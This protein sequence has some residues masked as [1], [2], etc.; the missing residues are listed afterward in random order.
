MRQRW[1]VASLMLSATVAA[2]AGGWQPVWATAWERSGPAFVH[3]VDLRVGE[4][5]SAFALL[6]TSATGGN[7]YASLA[8]FAANGA[9]LWLSEL[10]AVSVGGLAL[11]ADDRVGAVG[12][13]FG[14]TTAAVYRRSDGTLL[15]EC[16]WTG[17]D[18]LMEV[19][20]TRALV[21]TADGALGVRATD[22]GDLLLLR[23]DAQGGV[24]PEW[25]WSS[26]H[27]VLHSSDVLA[28]ADGGAVVTGY[29]GGLGGYYAVRFDA[30]GGVRFVDNELGDSGHPL[31]AV[32]V[33]VDAQDALLLAAAPESA[34]GVPQAQV[35]KIDSGGV[36]VWTRVVDEGAEPF[37]SAMVGAFTL[38]PGGDALIA[39]LSPGPLRAVRLA[40]DDGRVRWDARVAAE[41]HATTIAATP[42]GRVLVGG[43]EKVPGGNVRISV[44]AEFTPGGETCRF[45]ADTGMRSHVAARSHAGGWYLLGATTWMSGAGNEAIAQRYDGACDPLFADGFDN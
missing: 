4:D 20:G 24:L 1:M 43:Y 13:S 44:I 42:D 25:R 19:A 37:P 34:F 14:G 33:E 38:A 32:H 17:A 7:A 35:W 22:G 3:P 18:A 6:D 40:A 30:D 9:F 23:C 5:G 16:M 15:H 11:L 27:A 26:G 10:P 21:E 36:R 39:P 41:A 2:Q 29:E 8:R 28:T 12:W 45:A 31:D